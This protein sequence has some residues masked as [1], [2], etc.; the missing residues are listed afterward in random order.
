MTATHTRKAA[1]SKAAAKPAN[2][3]KP[4]ASAP[5]KPVSKPSNCGCGC[6]KPALTAKGTFLPGHDARL[7]GVLGRAVGSS[8]ST[9]EQQVQI[10]S[11]SPLL[12][13]KVAKIASTER[14]RV[15]E[16]A[17]KVVAK[18]AADKAYKAA[19]AAHMAS[20]GSVKV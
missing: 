16:K 17:A 11:L 20:H 3:P 6:G 13:A 12:Q 19:F 8:T 1:A 2:K 18:A 14:T 15:A 5:A 10:A 9:R 7:A 4:V